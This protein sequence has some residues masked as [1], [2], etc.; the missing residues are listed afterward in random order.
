MVLRLSDPPLLRLFA[1]EITPETELTLAAIVVF[2]IPVDGGV[3]ET[4]TS[5]ALVE[6]V[7]SLLVKICSRV[8]VRPLLGWM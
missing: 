8:P 7:S 1:I 3:K 6:L 4:L 2:W 5:L